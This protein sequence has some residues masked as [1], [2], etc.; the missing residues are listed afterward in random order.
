MLIVWPWYGAVAV[1]VTHALID[2]R[3]PLIWWRTLIGQ[4]QVD[5][6]RIRSAFTPPVEERRGTLLQ[7][8]FGTFRNEMPEELANGIGWNVAAM[9]VAF[10]QDQAAHVLVLGVVSW[11]VSSSM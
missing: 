10:W 5:M 3:V 2:T 9:Q 1:A 11:L 7:F 4:K 6:A 8:K